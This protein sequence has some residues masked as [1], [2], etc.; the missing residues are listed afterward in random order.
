MHSCKRKMCIMDCWGSIRNRTDLQKAV[1]AVKPAELRIFSGS[2][3]RIAISAL[4]CSVRVKPKWQFNF[5]VRYCFD[6][7]RR[8]DFV[9]A[10]RVPHSEHFPSALIFGCSFTSA[11]QSPHFTIE[12]PPHRSCRLVHG[13]IYDD[14]IYNIEL[15]LALVQVEIQ[16]EP[17]FCVMH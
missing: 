14:W 10:R 7:F 13:F 12:S 4:H 5:G 9:V 11:P 15:S 2:S 8:N 16:N 1:R 3:F 17:Q 6:P